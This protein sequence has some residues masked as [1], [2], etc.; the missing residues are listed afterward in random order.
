[1]PSHRLQG[2]EREALVLRLCG[3]LLDGEE[4]LDGG[5]EDLDLVGFPNL[6]PA[7]PF[8]EVAGN[9]A[10]A[11]ACGKVLNPSDG[12]IARRDAHLL[13]EDD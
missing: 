6:L 8:R 12:L 13:L 7:L 11:S 5:R 10:D 4:E 3:L 1:M 9:G 2:H